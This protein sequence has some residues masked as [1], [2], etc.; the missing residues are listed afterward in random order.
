MC[1]FFQVLFFLVWFLNETAQKSAHVR[2]GTSNSPNT[3]AQADTPQI[4]ITNRRRSVADKLGAGCAVAQLNKSQRSE[5][6]QVQ[7]SNCAGK[8]HASIL[9]ASRFAN[10]RSWRPWIGFL[11]ASFRVTH[12]AKSSLA[13]SPIPESL[14]HVSQSQLS[15]FF[16]SWRLLAVAKQRYSTNPESGLSDYLRHSNSC[17]PIA[18]VHQHTRQMTPRQFHAEVIFFILDCAQR[19]SY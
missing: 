19:A 12:L 16:A 17:K 3:R 10:R 13:R 14:P 9:S 5:P 18:K 8:F 4:G 2:G 11:Q 15:A 7:T 1:S 6:G